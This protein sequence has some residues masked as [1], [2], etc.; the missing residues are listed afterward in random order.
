MATTTRYTYFLGASK[1]VR[2][3]LAVDPRIRVV[4]GGGVRADMVDCN[5]KDGMFVFTS[6]APVSRDVRAAIKDRLFV[7]AA[8]L[9]QVV[10]IMT[11]ECETVA[12]PPLSP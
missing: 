4:V 9:G 8:D 11:V 3:A 2:T 6:P 12:V 7:V 1:R 10:R 5:V